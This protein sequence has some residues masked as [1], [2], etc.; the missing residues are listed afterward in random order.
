MTNPLLEPW[1]G[2]FGLPPFDRI[3]EAHYRPAFEAAMAEHEAEI[4]AIADNPAP[5]DFANTIEAMERA[6][7]TLDQVA[8][9]FFGFCASH[10]NDALQAIQ[11][12]V[13]PKLA[14]H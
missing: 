5:P 9:V 7:R 2:P 14:A 8:A 4:V 11:R 12:E 3:E 1:T 13:A 6:G 10:T